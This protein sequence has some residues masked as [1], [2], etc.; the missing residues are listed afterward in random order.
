MNN[1]FD[2]I[3]NVLTGVGISL[4]ITKESIFKPLKQRIH[5]TFLNKLLNCP[6][7]FSVWAGTLISILNPLTSNNTMIMYIPTIMITYIV[8]KIISIY[9]SNNEITLDD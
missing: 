6:S 8:T 3:L 1:T 2:L 5:N 4:I 7:C 9:I